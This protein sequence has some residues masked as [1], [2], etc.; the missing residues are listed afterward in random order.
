M[1]A[2]RLFLILSLVGSES[3][4]AQRGGNPPPD[5]DGPRGVMTATLSDGEPVS[6]FLEIGREIGLRERQRKDLMDIRRRLRAQNAP[7]VARLDSLRRLAGFELGERR[8]ISR[9]DADA[10]QRFS[11]WA[12]P[13]TDSIRLNNDIARAEARQVLDPDQRR[14]MDSIAAWVEGRGG[15]RRGGASTGP[16]G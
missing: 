12:R 8:S 3:L 1:R 5:F 11:A 14:R 6:F 10:L 13:V 7:F 4:A 2:P 9:R 16:R 15:R